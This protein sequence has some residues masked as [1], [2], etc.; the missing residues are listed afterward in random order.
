MIAQGFTQA[1]IDEVNSIKTALDTANQNHEAFKKNRPVL[2][3]ERVGKMN[4]AWERMLDVCKAAKFVYSENHAKLS[5]YL[6]NEGKATP[7]PAAPPTPP[8]AS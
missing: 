4:A 8:T 3:Q 6:I 5:R 1:R 7:P 2:T